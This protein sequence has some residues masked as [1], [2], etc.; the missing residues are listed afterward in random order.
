VVE[1]GEWLCAADGC[2]YSKGNFMT[3]PEPDP[4]ELENAFR[5]E[6]LKL[7][8]DA[9]KI[10]DLVIENMLSWHHSG[11]NVYCGNV[12]SPYDQKD[13]QRCSYLTGT[14]DLSTVS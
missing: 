10:N 8:R 11:F 12:I 1:F 4:K 14:D 2:F 9:G 5:C 13:G 7:L 6:V 3:G